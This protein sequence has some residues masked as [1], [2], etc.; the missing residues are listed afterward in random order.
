MFQAW[1]C[2]PNL[3][4]LVNVFAGSGNKQKLAVQGIIAVITTLA[5][6]CV[7]SSIAYTAAADTAYFNYRDTFCSNQTLLI[8]N[9]FFDASN[10][11]GTVILPGAASNGG[12]SVILVN[13]VF[14]QPVEID[15]NQ[16]ICEGD[17]LWVNGTAYH[18]KFYLG[19]EIVDNG[20]ANGCDSIIH[21]H[22]S[23]SSYITEYE[24][25][26]CEGDTIYI[27][28]TAYH[29]F[30][31][32]GEEMFEGAGAGG[33]DST[34]HVRINVITPP[35]SIITD[36]LCP[37]ASL[38]VNG[39]RYDRD[40]RSGLEILPGAS[41]TGCDSLVYLSLSFRELWV[42]IGDDRD[43]VKGDTVCLA[44]L[45]GLAPESLLWTPAP[46]CSDS[47]CTSNCI[48]PLANV[49]Y[50]LTATDTSGC[51]VSDDI[52]ITV[53]S[54]SRV[55]APN[56]F[57]PDAPEPNN[58]F[59]IST[60][61]GVVLIR[62]LLIADRWGGIIFDRENLTPGEAGQGW[63]GNWSGKTA[64]VGVYS[65]WAEFERFDGTRFEKSGTVSL[66]R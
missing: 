28:G 9:Q 21:I 55:Y 43:I 41:S 66:I 6:P 3:Q 7:A 57:N 37:D 25:S 52:T 49:S 29:A 38:T 10:P 8:G 24:T 44:P 60:D 45:L 54:D 53:S 50:H 32:S 14:R 4:S 30:H 65:F 2:L 33:C 59:F 27:N 40:N 23:F 47:S 22:L 42:Y 26:I 63:D 39:N 35:F 13:L 1:L 15:L 64:Q 56:V 48:Q 46:P 31:T 19:E 61:H 5:T 12:D 20:A 62:R 11:S 34:I 17:T 16:S 51:I 18:S 58:R 36:T